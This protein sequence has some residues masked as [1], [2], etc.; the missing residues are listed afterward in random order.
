MSNLMTIED[1]KVYFTNL[2]N[3]WKQSKEDSEKDEVAKKLFDALKNPAFSYT[4]FYHIYRQMKKQKIEGTPYIDSK[5]FNKWKE[6]GF[7]VKKG[8]KSSLKGITWL[9]KKKKGSKEED[10]EGV[11]IPK[12]YSLFHRKQVEEIK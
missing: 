8:E 12:Q 3:D 10:E 7:R 9:R 6:E 2:R 1:K 11:L 5:T 4:G